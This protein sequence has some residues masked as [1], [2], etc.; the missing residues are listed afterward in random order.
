MGWDNALLLSLITDTLMLTWIVVPAVLLGIVVGAIPGFSAQN[1]LI[2]LLPLTLTMDINVALAFMVSLYCATHLGGGIPA[3]LV[4]MPGTGGAAATTLDGYQMTL[5]GKAQQ[6]LVLCFVASTVGGL[7]TSVATVALLPYLAQ[8]GLYLRSVEMVAVMVFGLVLIAAI[9]ADDPLKGIIAGFFGLMIGAIG[10]DHIYGTPRAAFGFL[11]LYDGVPLVPALIGLFAISEAFSMMERSTVVPRS[12]VVDTKAQWA[13]TLE[14][15]R[16]SL[17]YWWLTIWTSFVGLLIGVVPGAGASIASFVAYQQA[18]MFSK[19]PEE[20]GKGFAPGVVAPESANNGVTS[21]TLV[22]LMAIGVPGGSTA[23]VMMVVLQYHGIVLGPRLFIES[24]DIAYGIFFSMTLSYIVMIFTI[25]P[26]ARYMSQVVL[27][28]TKILVPLIL[29]LT[30][31][32]AFA[33]REYVFDMGLAL[34][35]GVIGYIARKTNYHVTAILIGVILGPLFEQ[36]LLRSLRIGQ[37]DLTILFS[38]TTANVLWAFVVL[39]VLLPWLRGKQQE[40]QRKNLQ[41][42][43]PTALTGDQA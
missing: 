26:L 27:I 28:P 2:I 29:S 12:S 15:L 8:L 16:L 19:T 11:E 39:S 21:G 40:R 23:A 34:V 7:V 32:G 35:F 30:I 6:A 31:V 5:K 42:R 37:G 10:T 33:N 4:N 14:G 43:A 36:Y 13:D 1:T 38:S 25:L 3:I 20:F 24:P 18:R 9:A 41:D 17:K 22:P